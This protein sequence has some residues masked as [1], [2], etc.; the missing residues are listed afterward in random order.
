M[1]QL[2]NITKI[3]DKTGQVALDNISL[4][5]EKGEF[6][7]IVGRSGAGKSTFIKL[8]LKEINPTEGKL[9]IDDKD[10]TN[11]KKSKIPFLRR[12]LGIVFQDFRLL[13]NRT[14]YENVA[15]AMQ[16]VGEPEKKI[17]RRVPLALS[18]VGLKNRGNSYPQELSGGEQQ[19]VAIA[20]SIING[21]KIMI[22][23]EPTGNLDPKTSLGIMKIL[24]DINERGTTMV[25]ATHD[26]AVVDRM[27]KRVI[28]MDSGKIILDQQGGYHH[29]Y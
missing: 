28:T 15:Y 25:V 3:Y 29:E 12:E 21:P 23:D 19:R 26:K 11:I 14:V 27:Q 2:E 5:V 16:I 1:I 22:C 10:I 6:V 13:D 24:N 4:R 7:F 17:K 9:L 8:L 20:R 18:M